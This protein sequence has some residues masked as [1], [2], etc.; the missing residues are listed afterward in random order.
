MKTLRYILL[1]LV[2]LGASLCARA[3]EPTAQIRASTDTI[4]TLLRDPALQTDARK[5]E[6]RQLIREELDR[7]VDWATVARSSL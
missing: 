3:D 2:A 1:L 5:T 4:L 6:R 7:R